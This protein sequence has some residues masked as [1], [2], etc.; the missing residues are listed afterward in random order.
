M[1]PLSLSAGSH[2]ASVNLHVTNGELGHCGEAGAKTGS[3]Q[4]SFKCHVME[5]WCKSEVCYTFYLCTWLTAITKIGFPMEPCPVKTHKKTS[6]CWESQRPLIATVLVHPVLIFTLRSP[7]PGTQ[8]QIPGSS[9]LLCILTH[10][11]KTTKQK[12]VRKRD[13]RN[14]RSVM[15]Y[16][17][18]IKEVPTLQVDKRK[19][20]WIKYISLVTSLCGHWSLTW[21]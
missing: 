2:S 17:W 8:R 4:M 20:W 15:Y 14:R 19:R 3:L 21:Q 1:M 10:S 11:P 7:C 18:H 9:M 12:K 13:R 16:T 6:L 5:P